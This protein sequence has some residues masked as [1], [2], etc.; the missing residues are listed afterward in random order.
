MVKTFNLKKVKIRA[1]KINDFKKLKW[2][3]KN[4]D[5]ILKDY[6]FKIRNKYQEFWIASYNGK[7]IGEIHIFWRDK[8]RKKVYKNIRAY[9]STFRIYPDFQRKGIGTLLMKRIFSRLKQRRYKEVTIGAYV[10][11]KEIQKLYN[12]LGFNEQI[13]KDL[14]TS[15][16]PPQK[17]IL[18]LKRL[19]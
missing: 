19:K 12:K 17:F 8:D 10:K 16:K 6:V 3:W 7:I 14:D 13:K 1:G 5:E 2:G 4:S 15:T 18:Y 11:D 9:I